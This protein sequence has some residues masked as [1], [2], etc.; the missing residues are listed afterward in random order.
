MGEVG[1]ADGDV[2]A[3]DSKEGAADGKG[4]VARGQVVWRE[5]R[6]CRVGVARR[7]GTGLILT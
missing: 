2:G 7:R 5:G 6:G 3:A 1:A 4:R